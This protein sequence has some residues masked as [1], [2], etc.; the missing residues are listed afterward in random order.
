[1]LYTSV[2]QRH[3]HI[4]RYEK[5]AR[6]C[7]DPARKVRLLAR[8]EERVRLQFIDWMHYECGIPY[9]RISTELPVYLESRKGARAIRAD[10]LAHDEN[11]KPY[12]LVECKAAEVSL[13]EKTAT[14]VAGYNQKL[15]AP[16]LILTNGRQ[17]ACFKIEGK[18]PHPVGIE[19]F[20][21]ETSMAGFRSASYWNERGFLGSL[22]LDDKKNALVS[23]CNLFFGSTTKKNSVQYL[24]VPKIRAYPDLNHYYIYSGYRACSLMSDPDGTT[25]FVLLHSSVDAGNCIILIRLYGKD[26][27]PSVLITKKVIPLEEP[28]TNWFREELLDK[29]EHSRTLS[30]YD[31]LFE[32]LET[33]VLQRLS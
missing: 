26:V 3:Y 23:L 27:N 7:W 9:H 30:F 10:I 2:T 31:D 4:I 21:R 11:F 25:W 1:M 14:Q 29:F 13:S 33:K 19:T 8:P 32:K 12:L 22:S 16:F 24:E 18:T 28:L 20:Q 6:V 15:K 17:D 5:N